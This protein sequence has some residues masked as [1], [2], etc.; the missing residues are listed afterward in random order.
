MLIELRIDRTDPRLWHLRLIERLV[1]IPE[2][3][4]VVSW[5]SAAES[6]PSCINFLFVFERLI[7]GLPEGGP[8]SRAREA[9]FSRSAGLFLDEPDL[10]LD[11][12]GAAEQGSARTW[13]VTFDRASGEAAA[14]GALLTGNPPAI[15]LIDTQTGLPVA[16]ACPGTETRGIILSAFEDCLAR[17]TTLIVAAVNG[18]AAPVPREPSK[19]ARVRCAAGAKFTMK[20]LMRI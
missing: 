12:C 11:L 5:R 20:S 13:S 9:S 4:V 3:R 7:N 15:D 1:Q 16:C 6:L 2:V 8:A 14:L 17:T 18:A 19:V 10:V